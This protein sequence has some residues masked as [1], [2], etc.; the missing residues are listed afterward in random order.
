MRLWAKDGFTVQDQKLGDP[1][2]QKGGFFVV[3]QDLVPR[4]DLIV[5]RG[6][7]PS[8]QV[9]QQFARGEWGI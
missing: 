2:D 4:L 3:H 6:W 8:L 1:N 7:T 5:G 9:V